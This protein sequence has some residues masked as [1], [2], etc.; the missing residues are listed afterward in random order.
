MDRIPDG[1]IP[2]D[3]FVADKQD[4]SIPEGSIP[5]D[6]FKADDISHGAIPVDQFVSDQDKYSTPMQRLGNAAEGLAQGYAGPVAT[7]AEK[8][9]SD[10]GVP[11]LSTEEQVGRHSTNPGEF[12]ASQAIGLGAGM[13]TGTGE[14]G[15][16]AK[17]LEHI[18]QGVSFLAKAGS[19][20]LKGA[21]SMGLIQGGDELSK[22]MLGQS[23]PEHPVSA[24]ISNIGAAALLGAVT[25][26]IFSAIGS[27]A[28]KGLSALEDAKLG[29]KF[30]SAVAGIGNSLKYSSGVLPSEGTALKQMPSIPEGVHYPSFV[31]GQQ[32]ADIIKNGAPAK[33]AKYGADWAGYQVGGLPGV[34]AAH[35]VGRHLEKIINKKLPKFSQKVLGPALIR[36]AAES[37]SIS[38]MGQIIDYSGSIAKGENAIARGVEA[39]FKSGSQEALNY[40]MSE[41]DREKLREFIE[42]GGVDAQIRKQQQIQSQQ[43]QQGFAVGG[44]VQPMAELN[45]SN[46]IAEHFPEQNM[47]LNTAKARVSTYLNSVRPLPTTKLPFDSEHK[48]KHK[49]REYDK[50]LDLANQPLSVLKQIKDGSLVPKTMSTFTAMYPELHSHLAKRITKEIIK[51]QLD[52]TKKPPYH[53][54]QALS[55]FLGSNLDS[56]LSQPNMM[57]AQN[58]FA[59]QRAQKQAPQK[60]TNSLGKSGQ[61]LMTDDQARERRLNKN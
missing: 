9:L 8:K 37:G 51:H 14:A 39:L 56:T 42:N 5:V 44:E 11:G 26:G 15:L 4:N 29:N 49:K 19:S 24:A 59:Q 16:I 36:A 27:G 7:Y 18:P 6:Q 20:A 45:Q 47:L 21:I 34:V 41:K 43:A 17:G 48:D 61:N 53:V 32:I 55:L 35:V 12:A 25:G 46:S 50:V 31:K 54:R 22:S 33:I 58:V 2:V 57:A 38:K 1:A 40:N 23:D 3:Q 10:L 30:T 52:E 60:S 13:L 28:S